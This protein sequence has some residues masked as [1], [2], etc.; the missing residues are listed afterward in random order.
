[1]KSNHSLGKIILALL[2]IVVMGLLVTGCG[3]EDG[4][5]GAGN[6]LTPAR[7]LVGTWKAPLPVKVNFETD[8]C[9]FG[10]LSLVLTQMWDIT[11][12]I[13]EGIDENHVDVKMTFIP[14]NTTIVGGCSGT[15]VVPEVSPMYLKGTISSSRMDVAYG[16]T[17]AGVFNFTTDILTGTFDFTW[18]GV[19]DQREYTATNGLT[20]IRQ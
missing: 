6:N 16:S 2:A 4:D 13:T 10:T 8:F 11:F 17:P 7:K 9:D 19:Y 5:S 18:S 14:S 20:L 12:V 15:G 3:G 1:M